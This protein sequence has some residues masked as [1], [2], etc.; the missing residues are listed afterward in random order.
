M[1]NLALVAHDHKK[2]NMVAM[3]TSTTG[4]RLQAEVGWTWSGC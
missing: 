2:D 3:A 4:G 1:M